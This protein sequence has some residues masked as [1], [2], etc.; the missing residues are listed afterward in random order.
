MFIQGQHNNFMNTLGITSYMIASRAY[1]QHC[2]RLLLHALLEN[3]ARGL[4][5]IKPGMPCSAQLV[6]IELA[7]SS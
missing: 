5:G 2:P 6:F 1:S 3:F 4:A 7:S